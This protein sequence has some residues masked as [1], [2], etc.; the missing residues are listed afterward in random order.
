M[1]FSRRVRLIICHQSHQGTFAA[2]HSSSFEIF[3]KPSQKKRSKNCKIYILG[4]FRLEVSTTV[5]TYS[6]SQTFFITSIKNYLL[7]EG[8]IQHIYFSRSTV[9]ANTIDL[10]LNP[11]RLVVNHLISTSIDHF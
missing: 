2:H 6:Q 5:F 7:V 8:S 11:R 1:F 4:G 9:A 3:F 10:S